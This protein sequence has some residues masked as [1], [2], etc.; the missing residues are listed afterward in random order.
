MPP[1]FTEGYIYPQLTKD[2]TISGLHPYHFLLFKDG[3]PHY[4]FPRQKLPGD[5]G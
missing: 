3:M 4:S 1:V 5:K 2:L